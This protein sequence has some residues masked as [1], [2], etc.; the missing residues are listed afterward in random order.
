MNSLCEQQILTN[1]CNLGLLLIYLKTINYSFIT[2]SPSS[3]EK[4]NSRVE[5]EFAKDLKGI[6]GW[7]RTFS[8]EILDD[9]MVQ[10]F[11]STDIAIKTEK[12]WKSQ[13]RVSSLNQQLFVHSAYPTIDEHAVFF[14]PDTYRFANAIQQ[15]LLSNHKPI[16]RAVD[17]GTGSGV[18]AIL[19]ASTFPDSEVVAVDVNDE[20]L[21]LAR[22]NIEAAS[23]NNIRLVH[24]N[25]LNNVEGN[26]DLIIANPPFLLDPSERTYRHGGGELGSGLSLDIVDTALKRLNPEGVLLLY[27]GVAIVNGYDAFL[28]AV[29][30]K[31][32][33]ASFI[34]EYTEI[35]PDIFGEELVNKEY[36]LV[37]RVAAILLLVQKK[38]V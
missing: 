22:I 37:D 10:F 27:T 12:G 1:Q 11:H 8:L 6:F 32:K 14:G 9:F 33:L 35:D 17:I 2:I 31:L 29:N 24:S 5:N 23:I 28:E 26:F 4:V 15:Y 34:Y 21:Y 19:I 3:H 16:S 30:L 18:G 25:L 36:M 38:S 7:N 20:A 13:Y